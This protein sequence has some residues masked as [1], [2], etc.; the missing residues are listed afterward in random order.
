MPIEKLERSWTA[1]PIG[2]VAAPLRE[3]VTSE[4]RRAILDFELKPGQ[5][6]IERELITQL[7]VSRATVREAIRA[8]DAEGLVKVEP[9]RGAIVAV[10]TREEAAEMYE[11]RAVLESLL[12]RFFIERASDEQVQ[13]L[14]E[15]V[16]E[17]AEE[18]ARGDDVYDLLASKDRF[19]EVLEEGAKSP[20]LIQQLGSLKARVRVLRATSLSSPGRGPEVVTELMSILEAIEARDVE[21]AAERCVDHI[22]EA[23][24]TAMRGLEPATDRSG[25]TQ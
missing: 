4:L 22:R 18:T 16:E 19:Y 13:R 2:R 7:G 17:I 1:A 15:T 10:P 6:L 20:T 21:A 23:A 24:Q 12:V 8:L 5:R 11:I 14:R 9:Q 3:Q 25:Q